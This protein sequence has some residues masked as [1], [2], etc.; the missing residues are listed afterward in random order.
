MV[1]TIKANKQL[2]QKLDPKFELFIDSLFDELVNMTSEYLLTN[3]G[4]DHDKPNITI[5]SFSELIGIPINLNEFLKEYENYNG[6]FNS[7]LNHIDDDIVEKILSKQTQYSKKATEKTTTEITTIETNATDVN[8]IGT[9]TTEIRTS[10]VTTTTIPIIEFTEIISNN[11]DTTYEKLLDT[12]VKTIKTSSFLIDQTTRTT[13]TITTTSTKKMKKQDSSNKNITNIIN[14]QELN[15]GELV[16]DPRDCTSFYT[17]FKGKIIAKRKCNHNLYFD[18]NLKVCNWPEE[19]IFALLVI[20]I[21]IKIFK[22]S[23]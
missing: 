5:P 2:P 21:K 9:T 1:N 15:D 3:N 6:K 7:S 17:C 16:P 14:C 20:L 11:F 12:T 19:V 8:L 23:G 10:I 18:M 13:K 4:T 22:I